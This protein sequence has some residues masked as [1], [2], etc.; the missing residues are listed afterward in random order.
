MAK[1]NVPEFLDELDCGIFKDK[2]AT[3][4]S[5]V[6]LGVLTHDKKGKVTVEFS[7]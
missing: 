4:L 6:A 2:L 5:E 1:T 7:L 3:A